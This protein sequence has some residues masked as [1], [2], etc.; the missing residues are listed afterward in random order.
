M[1]E[2]PTRELA[3]EAVK[4]ALETEG[5]EPFRGASKPQ[6]IYEKEL[7]SLYIV[8]KKGLGVHEDFPD[9]FKTVFEKE[10]KYEKVVLLV[11]S[12]L[13]KEEIRTNIQELFDDLSE[14]DVARILRFAITLYYLDFESHKFVVDTIKRFIEVFPEHKETVKRFTKFFI[15]VKLASDIASGKIKDRVTKEIQ[16]QLLSLE[17]G[18][19]RST[20]SDDYLAKIA[21]IVF[22]LPNRTLNSILKS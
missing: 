2:K 12:S 18:I 4:E 7:I 22:E 5:I 8:G 16:K 10:M 20:P 1:S 9:T 21:R 19:P 6:D 3:I 11:N 17:T 14:N 15:A 13:D